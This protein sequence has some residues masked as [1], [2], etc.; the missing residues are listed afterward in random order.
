M[1]DV[2][3][4]T[5]GAGDGQEFVQREHLGL[6]YLSAFLLKAGTS[7]RIIDSRFMECDEARLLAD[8]REEQPVLVGFSLFL[9]NVALVLKVIRNLRTSGWAGHITLGGHHATFNYRA[10]LRDNA[11]VTSI[12]LG[13][14]EEALS[15]LVGKLKTGCSWHDVAN[16]A[17]RGAGDDVFENACRPLVPNLDTLPFPDRQ[18][19]SHAIRASGVAAMTSSRGCYGQCSFCSIRAFYRMSPGKRWRMRSP[20][21]VVDEMEALVAEYGVQSITFLDDNF[22]G[23]GRPGRARAQAI[24]AELLKRRI[25]VNWSIAC[26]PNDVDSETLRLLMRAGLRRVDLGVESWSSRQLSLYNKGITLEQNERAVET[27]RGLGLEYRLYLIPIDPYV[28]ADELLES[29]RR[30]RQEG[31]AHVPGPFF[32]RLSVLAGTDVVQRLAADGMLRKRPDETDYLGAAECAFREPRMS[33]TVASLASLDEGFIRSLSRINN[34]FPWYGANSA[35]VKF[36]LDLISATGNMIL[37]LA[38]KVVPAHH[39][40]R[41]VEAK[42]IVENGLAELAASLD[43][44]ADAKQSG[45]FARFAQVTV[46]IGAMTMA[47]PPPEIVRLAETLFGTDNRESAGDSDT[48]AEVILQAREG[49]AP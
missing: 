21:N 9:T 41:T 2:L 33:E 23:P 32:N 34:L 43:D 4:I 10:I 19:Y 37:E 40:G 8:I 20:E 13:E 7:V 1:T 24:A 39:C 29:I 15:E 46:R 27:V 5:W 18:T 3:L 11:D 35:E 6:C 17:Y 30:M 36:A 22:I 48:G 14:A 42:T 16:V 47:Y 28:S 12:V 25:A 49:A 45:R 44:V 26:R 31:T 38:A